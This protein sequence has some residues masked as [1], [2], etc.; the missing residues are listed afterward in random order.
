MDLLLCSGGT[1]NQGEQARRGL[2][3]GYQDG[4]LSHDSFQAAVRRV[5]ALRASLAQPASSGSRNP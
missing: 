1:V 5:L 2:V 3:A 4:L